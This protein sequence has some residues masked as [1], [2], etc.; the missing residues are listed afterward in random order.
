MKIAIIGYGK[1]GRMVE[2]AARLRHHEIG[3]VID[4]HNLAD[5]TPALLKNNDVAIEFSTP[6]S[7]YNNISACFDAGIP[8]VSGTTGWLERMEEVKK[9]CDQEHKALVYSSN[10]SLGVNILFHL[11]KKLAEIMNRYENYH[12]SIQEIH[13]ITKKDAP[14]GTAIT[15]AGDIINCLDRKNGWTMD[16]APGSDSIPVKAIRADQVVGIHE[17]CYESENDRLAIK[18]SAANRKGLAA[19]A[20]LAAEFIQGRTGFYTMQD[21]LQ[22]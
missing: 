14:S 8:V 21:L 2:E 5:L 22:F 6:A 19:G 15:L 16:P 17:V 18:H 3:L 10:F 12:V 9:R 1:M 20:I 7:A 4:L 11:N 13:H